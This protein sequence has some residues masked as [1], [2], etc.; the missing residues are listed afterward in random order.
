MKWLARA[1][2]LGLGIGL[3][4]TA[5][6]AA[7][8]ASPT[9]SIEARQLIDEGKAAL[10]H[11][12]YLRDVA[13]KEKDIIKLSCIND[14]LVMMK[15]QVNV[16]ER[17]ESE[18]TVNGGAMAQITTA[19]VNVRNLRS[20]ADGCAGDQLAGN[21]ESS[22]SFTGPT[23]PDNPF[24]NPWAPPGGAVEPPGYASPFD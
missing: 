21:A 23:P 8:D 10:R 24:T 16:M 17:L 20:E 13:R 22:N 15:A 4:V 18:M 6:Q 2:I 1:A 14:K 12:T 19:G 11:V 3:G 9:S 7:P 5:I